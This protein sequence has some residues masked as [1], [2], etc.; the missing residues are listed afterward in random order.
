MQNVLTTLCYLEADNKYLMLLRNK[1]TNDIN[2]NKYIGVGG[3][4]EQGESPDDC[5]RREIY[6]ETGIMVRTVKLRG[7]ITFVM[8]EICEYT[9]L[10]TSDDFANTDAPKTCPE[11]ELKWVDKSDILKLELWEGDKIFLRLLLE[12]A[13]MFSLKLI[14]DG[15]NL[16]DDDLII[17]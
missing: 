11:G 9:F 17:Y 15:D 6:E 13:K 7:I 5:I 3:H 8:G 1:K 16:V 10:Y 4:M 12:D 2:H 14:Y